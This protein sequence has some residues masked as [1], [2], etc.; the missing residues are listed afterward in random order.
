ML[1]NRFARI[2]AVESYWLEK[3]R[4]AICLF[5]FVLAAYLAARSTW[6]VAALIDPVNQGI[7]VMASIST[8]AG[9][10]VSSVPESM[11]F[12]DIYLFG[13]PEKASVSKE[14]QTVR[15][16]PQTTL[17]L[18]LKGIVSANPMSRAL[19][20]IAEKKPGSEDLVYAVGDALPGNARVVE[21][22]ADRII[23]SRAGRHETLFLHEQVSES[24]SMGGT[25][26]ISSAGDG[27]HWK[28]NEAYWQQRLAD[29]PS[30]AR[31]VGVD[32]YK[33]GNVQKGYKLIS[34]RGSQLLKDLGLAPGDI[35]HEVNGVKLTSVHQGLAAY[36][37]IRN[38]SE[39][40][41]LVSRNGQRQ[42]RVYTI[43]K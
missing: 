22:Y 25:Q 9:S 10:R 3:S 19:A 21:I 15:S 32:I 36:Q 4:Q 38:A 29:I 27:T 13:V 5:L 35:L 6:Q 40:R 42:T 18:I 33:E 12:P 37:K 11:D 16:A 26:T 31:E 14:S 41:V 20:I 43:D 24:R 1:L 8:G 17:N 28:I 2:L 7:D 34:A 23:L 39:I 30:L